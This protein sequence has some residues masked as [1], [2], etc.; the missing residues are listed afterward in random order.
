M[1]GLIAVSSFGGLF[2]VLFSAA[3]FIVSPVEAQLGDEFRLDADRRA[4]FDAAV[5]RLTFGGTPA[6]AGFNWQERHDGSNHAVLFFRVVGTEPGTATQTI[7]WVARHVA[8]SRDDMLTER[9]ASSDECPV[10][11]TVLEDMNRIPSLGIGHTTPGPANPPPNPSVDGGTFA[12]WSR[13]VVQRQELVTVMMITNQG[14]VA[15]FA[16][17]AG[18]CLYDCWN[19]ER[20]TGWK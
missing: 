5:S 15:E 8:L 9:W 3:V 10:L 16:R 4:Q 2:G 18:R 13:D 11:A 7:S 1:L 20:P 14:P 12:V 6:V 17:N 19:D